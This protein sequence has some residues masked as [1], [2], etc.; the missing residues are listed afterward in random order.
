MRAVTEVRGV[1]DIA[2]VYQLTVSAAVALTRAAAVANGGPATR[3][4]AWVGPTSKKLCAA[5]RL[6]AVAAGVAPIVKESTPGG[7][8]VVA[9]IV[10]CCVVPSG[11]LNIRL[12]ASPGFGFTDRSTEIAGGVPVGPISWAPVKLPPTLASLK[13]NGDPATSSLSDTRVP[14][15]GMAIAGSPKVPGA[16]V[17]PITMLSVVLAAATE[18]LPFPV[19]TDAV[20]P[21][22]PPSAVAR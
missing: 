15:V 12:S 22:S 11:R 1:A 20:P 9:V 4:A 19:S 10:S 16:A 5:C 18:M 8:A 6:A 7:D 2:P 14:G 17:P 3:W 13:P 21:A